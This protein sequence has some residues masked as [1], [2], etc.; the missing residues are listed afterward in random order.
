MHIALLKTVE[1]VR[2]Y[3]NNRDFR[4]TSFDTETTDLNYYML[5][6]VGCSFCNGQDACYI[7]LYEDKSRII[8]FLRKLFSDNIEF[9]VMQNAPFDLKV[10]HKEGITKVTHNIF[11]TMTASHLIDEN[12]EKGL[13]ELAKRYLK[14]VPITY[15]EAVSEGFQSEKFYTY[16]TNDAIWTWELH[17]IL[18][19]KLYELG[20][21]RLFF[22]V[23]MPFQFV[24][25]DMSINGVLVYKWGFSG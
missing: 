20:M 11:C 14:E 5:E 9:L 2:D 3:F 25:M 23:E 12:R 22:E 15:K 16:A 24:I 8:T 13:K 6:M 10:L 7:D 17:K 19:K 1:E 4:V 21:N 18:N